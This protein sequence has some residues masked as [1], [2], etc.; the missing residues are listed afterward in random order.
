MSIDVGKTGDGLAKKRNKMGK[1][2]GA[3]IGLIIGILMIV[4]VSSTSSSSTSMTS[5]A[6]QL[7][8]AEQVAVTNTESPSG[9]Y[10]SETFGAWK[11][12]VLKKLSR[13]EAAGSYHFG[14]EYILINKI[15]DGKPYVDAS[16]SLYYKDEGEVGQLRLTEFPDDSLIINIRA[17]S[18]PEDVFSVAYSIAI[19]EVSAQELIPEW[20]PS[21]NKIGDWVVNMEELGVDE[22]LVFF[23]D[24]SVKLN[25]SFYGPEYKL[26]I[27][28]PDASAFAQTPQA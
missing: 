4:A 7:Q 11:D 2:G 26:R 23:G 25:G 18:I 9:K 16:Y 21:G 19:L 28:E 3:L 8:E 10:A 15:S 27:E 13:I 22:K 17:Y 14:E 12:D 5:S 24:K 1:K 6:K 20:K